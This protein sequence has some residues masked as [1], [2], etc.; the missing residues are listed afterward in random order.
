[1]FRVSGAGAG[2]G[3]GAVVVAEIIFSKSKSRTSRRSIGTEE[4]IAS[5]SCH[6]GECSS[7]SQ[8]SC[9]MCRT[10]MLIVS[11]F[12]DLVIDGSLK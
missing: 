12:K 1:M 7:C 4:K 8:S 9:G 5:R 3:A 10:M 6:S 11:S 2:A